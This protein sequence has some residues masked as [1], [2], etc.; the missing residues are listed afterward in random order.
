MERGTEVALLRA[1]RADQSTP[2][3]GS[4]AE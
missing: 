2:G 3:A 1:E 4:G